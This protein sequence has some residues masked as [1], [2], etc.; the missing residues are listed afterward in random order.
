MALMQEA[1]KRATFKKPDIS[2]LIPKGQ[3]DAVARIAAAGLRL[4]YSP[5]MRED[6]MQAVQAPGDAATKLS[7]NV[8]GLLLV[9]DQKAPQ[10]LPVEAMFPAAM[11]ILGDAA[12]VLTAA[13]Q[14]VTQTDYNDAAMQIMVELAKRMGAN[15]DQIMQ[16]AAGALPQGGED[17]TEGDPEM[18]QGPETEDEPADMEAQS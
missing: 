6:V 4:L 1:K 18:A 14:T 9:L 13:G 16:A 11:E 15:D 3:E 17:D 12:E 5:D 8:S 10:G 2:S 7:S